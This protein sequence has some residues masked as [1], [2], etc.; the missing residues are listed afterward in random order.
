MGN[1]LSAVGS[2][3]LAKSAAANGLN[4]RPISSSF[5]ARG[6]GS[7]KVT[8]LNLEMSPGTAAIEQ[9]DIN[10]MTSRRV[11]ASTVDRSSRVSTVPPA[12]P[13]TLAWD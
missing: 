7:A 10:A 9:R 6:V 5:R 3:A 2:F 11:M 12:C 13:D 1:V 8:A 4:K